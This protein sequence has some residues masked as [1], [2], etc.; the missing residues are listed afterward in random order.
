MTPLIIIGFTDQNIC[1]SIIDNNGNIYPCVNEECNILTRYFSSEIFYDLKYFEKH[2]NNEWLVE[3]NN[4]V[5]NI[6]SN[7]YLKILPGFKAP[8]QLSKINFQEYNIV[9]NPLYTFQDSE[10]INTISLSLLT[11]IFSPIVKSIEQM[12]FSTDSLNV[13][14][15]IPQYLNRIT[16]I[17]LYKFL[18]SIK[19]KR[20][21]FINHNI[22]LSFYMLEKTISSDV[23]I[24]NSDAESF[25]AGHVIYKQNNNEVSIQNNRNIS[26]PEIGYINNEFL[27]N[28][29][30]SNKLPGLKNNKKNIILLKSAITN[31]IYGFFSKDALTQDSLKISYNLLNNIIENHLGQKLIEKIETNLNKLI[32]LIEKNQIPVISSGPLFMFESFEKLIYEKY[33]SYFSM[34]DFKKIKAIERPV[35]G[36]I[37]L[38]N[39][40]KNNPNNYVK[41]VNNYSILMSSKNFSSINLIPEKFFPI[42][43]GEKIF[44]SKELKIEA[45]ETFDKDLISIDLRWGNNLNSL[46]NTLLC[47][48]LVEVDQKDVKHNN[49]LILNISLSGKKDGLKG[50]A[51]AVINN[52]K[53]KEHNLNF[54][55]L[56]S[57]SYFSSKDFE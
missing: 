48:I 2:T 15:V 47:A 44:I 33:T 13:I 8:H 21:K 25:H 30:E 49:N 45:T 38:I 22:A 35:E 54:P 16:F 53:T 7:K 39:Y 12:G 6:P 46:N 55:E 52:M 26:L 20:I 40:L 27:K 29:I 17:M 37:K 50:T 42:P 28:C 51:I 19:F 24:L 3:L 31:L 11:Y 14:C 1:S 5:N 34:A 32:P 43:S 4:I 18:K 56:K 10:D 36:V 23:L 57:I 9:K 41:T